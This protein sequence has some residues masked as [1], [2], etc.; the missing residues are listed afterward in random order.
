MVEHPLQHRLEEPPV[1]LLRRPQHRFHLSSRRHLPLEL[2]HLLLQLADENLVVLPEVHLLIALRLHRRCRAAGAVLPENLLEHADQGFRLLGLDDEPVRPQSPGE[3]LVLRVRVG[4]GVV[5][6][7]YPAE[8]GVLLPLAAELKAVHDRHENIGDDHV[9][10]VLT[11]ELEGL[12]SV[13]RRDH[14]VPMPAEEGLQHVG[15]LRVVI[16]DEDMLH[17]YLSDTEVTGAGSPQPRRRM[18][19]GRWAFLCSRSTPR[20][21]RAHGRRPWHRR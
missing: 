2:D 17:G 13:G 15:V 8:H 7:G 11:G 21:K 1:P 19:R 4:G 20:P 3:L 10:R 9:R 6:K 12:G 5:D 16:D 18:C 14:S